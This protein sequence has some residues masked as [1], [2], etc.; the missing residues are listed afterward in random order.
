MTQSTD[1]TNLLQEQEH[2]IINPLLA[3][4]AP[5]KGPDFDQNLADAVDA[6]DAA[7][8]EYPDLPDVELSQ[9]DFEQL[10]VVEWPDLPDLTPPW[11]ES[12]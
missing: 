1:S 6:F 10:S 7:M 8:V 11:E 12:R 9:S 5:P 4:S 2:R 3:I